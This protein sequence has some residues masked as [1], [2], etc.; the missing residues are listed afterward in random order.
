MF[1]FDLVP[2]FHRNILDGKAKDDGPY[3]SECHLHIPIHN[4][5]QNGK[6]QNYCPVDD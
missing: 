5:Y 6:Q 1:L 2:T 4:F 3:H